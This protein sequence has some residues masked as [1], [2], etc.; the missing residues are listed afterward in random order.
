MTLSPSVIRSAALLGL[1]LAGSIAGAASISTQVVDSA[2][3]ALADAAVYAEPA[4]GQAL[5][6]PRRI[7]EI[8]QKDRKFFPLV[9]VIQTGMD[10]SFPN[11]DTVRHHVYSFSTPKAF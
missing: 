3:Q 1:A 10:I 2:G 9:T 5:P 8:E 11:N 6:K 4:S 7:N